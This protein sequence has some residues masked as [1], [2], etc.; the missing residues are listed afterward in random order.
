[1]KKST[2]LTLI[3][4]FITV[5]GVFAE[6]QKIIN[7]NFQNWDATRDDIVVPDSC[8]SN[9]P[10]PYMSE[11]YLDLTTSDGVEEISV[12]LIKCG[13]SPECNSK[14][15]NRGGTGNDAI[16]VGFVSLM[17]V[18][19]EMDTIGE[20]IFGPISQIDSIRFGH[21]HTGSER[22]IRFY[23]SYDGEDWEMIGEDEFNTSDDS[24]AGEVESIVINDDDVYVRIT[25]GVGNDGETSQIARLHS[26][27]VFGE[28]GEYVP[29]VSGIKEIEK[30]N[31]EVLTIANGMYKI[32]GDLN[33]MQVYNTL[34]C[35][36]NAN[37][38]LN[39]NTI[40]L[41]GMSN[42]IYIIRAE[43][44]NGKISSAKV[45]KY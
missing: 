13:V 25:S 24:Q 21:S 32:K 29:P 19:E 6:S 43:D 38:N 16:S 39:T 8:E 17:K 10:H 45:Y 7:E 34:G 27:E 30:S 12:T 33:T 41:T 1:M 44:S 11:G 3:I 36:V 20:F 35:N 28:P 26:L 15:V 14:R 23:T 5:F 42:G 22:G 37:I 4:S 9:L 31:L 40:D 18:T 2:L